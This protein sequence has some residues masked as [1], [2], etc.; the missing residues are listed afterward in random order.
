VNFTFT[1][2]VTFSLFSVSLKK[3]YLSEVA[4]NTTIAQTILQ[5]NPLLEAFGNAKTSENDNSSRY[6]E[7]IYVK[8]V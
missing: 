8:C 1:I 2:D 7:A 4:G 5:A 6:V 3:Q